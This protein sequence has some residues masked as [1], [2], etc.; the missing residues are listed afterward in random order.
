MLYNLFLLWMSLIIIITKIHEHK[1][2]R[3]YMLG[4]CHPD[5]ESHKTEHLGNLICIA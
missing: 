2:L 4:L 5:K 1:L 3:E